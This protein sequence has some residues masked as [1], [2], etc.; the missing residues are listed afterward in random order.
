MSPRPH[1]DE[2]EQVEESLKEHS[3]EVW[4]LVKDPNTYVYVSGLSRLEGRLDKTMKEFAGSEDEWQNIKKELVD[5]G[6]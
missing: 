4:D 3:S 1:F 2:P 6:H 5:S